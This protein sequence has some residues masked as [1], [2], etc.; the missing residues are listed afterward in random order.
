MTGGLDTGSG[1]ELRI[2]GTVAVKEE[3]D[4]RAPERHVRQV[5]VDG[6]SSR[7]SFIVESPE[8]VDSLYSRSLIRVPGPDR[9]MQG[10]LCLC[11]SRAV[12]DA[13]HT[14]SSEN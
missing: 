5:C 1:T 11:T 8:G 10:I 9:V 4:L 3:G 6:I 12:D 2:A 13:S 7:A 14:T